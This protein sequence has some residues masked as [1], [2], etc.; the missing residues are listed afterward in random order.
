MMSDEQDTPAEAATAWSM[1]ADHMTLDTVMA[2]ALLIHMNSCGIY[3]APP[4][5]AL[6]SVVVVVVVVERLEAS[7]YLPAAFESKMSSDRYGQH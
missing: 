2:A 1:Y 4:D 5:L 6:W 3:D 7:F